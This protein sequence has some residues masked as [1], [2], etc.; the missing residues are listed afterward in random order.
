MDKIKKQDAI[1]KQVATLLDIEDM[2]KLS[3]GDMLTFVSELE[4]KFAKDL[5]EKNPLFADLSFAIEKIK[6]VYEPTLLE[7]VHKEA[8]KE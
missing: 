4:E 3:I 8:T 5:E 1:N 7:Y 2:V 6:N